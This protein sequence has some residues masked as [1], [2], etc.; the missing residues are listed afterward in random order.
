MGKG[1]FDTIQLATGPYEITKETA[2][3]MADRIRFRHYKPDELKIAKDFI[4]WFVLK[5]T[6]YFD[7]YLMTKEAHKIL[8]LHAPP[9]LKDI[10]PWLSRIDCVVFKGKDVF[11]IEF[12]DRLRKSGIGEL[13]SY[14]QLY[15]EQ[16][17]PTGPLHLWYVVRHDDESL[18]ST[19]NALGI[20]VRVVA[21]FG[22]D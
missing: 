13:V 10:V 15:R 22:W 2:I 9:M 7:Y 19:C 14:K 5:G 4:R 16:Y 20:A 12:K 18:H 21:P 11:I 8:E 3:A 17:Q 1:H 6:Y